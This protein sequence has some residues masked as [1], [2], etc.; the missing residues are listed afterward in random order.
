[1][2]TE[3]ITTSKKAV[4]G[5]VESNNLLVEKSSKYLDII[6]NI[7]VMC[8]RVQAMG[9]HKDSAVDLATMINKTIATQMGG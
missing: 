5:L 7:N 3:L 6:R 1:M 8:T 2:S 4:D 9:T